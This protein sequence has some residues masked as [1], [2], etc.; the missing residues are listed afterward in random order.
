MFIYKQ[1]K[2]TFDYSPEFDKHNHELV[3]YVIQ[4]YPRRV[5]STAIV[6]RESVPTWYRE[7]S[8]KYPKQSHTIL[9]GTISLVGIV[10]EMVD[11]PDSVE[12]NSKPFY[13]PSAA[14]RD[15]SA[16]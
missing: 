5:V 16:N 4:R 3:G 10:E 11:D 13:Q 2:V 15:P 8:K 7:A 12:D 14:K 9:L 1:L 6:T